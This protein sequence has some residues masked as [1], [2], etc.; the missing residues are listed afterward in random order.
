MAKVVQHPKAAS[1]QRKLDH[2]ARQA[3]EKEYR[4]QR[5]GELKKTKPERDR[6]KA[7]RRLELVIVERI[8]FAIE[9]TARALAERKFPLPGRERKSAFFDAYQ[10]LTYNV[11][12]AAEA[13]A[14]QAAGFPSWSEFQKA[15]GLADD[16]GTTSDTGDDAGEK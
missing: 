14:A 16:D 5:R 11:I 8:P 13:I 12:A 4:R 15:Q 9:M 3:E 7:L 6:L 2:D 1:Y 10:D